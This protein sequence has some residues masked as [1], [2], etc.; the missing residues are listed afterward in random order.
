MKKMLDELRKD[1]EELIRRRE[2]L[3]ALHRSLPEGD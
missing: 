1:K 3:K 2:E